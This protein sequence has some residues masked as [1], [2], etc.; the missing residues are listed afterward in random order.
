[1]SFA[2]LGTSWARPAPKRL[3]RS[4]LSGDHGQLFL[5]VTMSVTGL[6]LCIL[7]SWR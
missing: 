1:M 5:G 7:D 3:T 6:A 2:G 4:S